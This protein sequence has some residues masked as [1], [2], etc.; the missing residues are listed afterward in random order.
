MRRFE[1]KTMDA[2]GKPDVVALE[3]HS[4]VLLGKLADPTYYRDLRR[5]TT[6]SALRGDVT[7]RIQPRGKVRSEGVE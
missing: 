3:I 1:T 5:V 6:Q 7:T 2:L 4:R